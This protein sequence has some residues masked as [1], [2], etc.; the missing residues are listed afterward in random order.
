M[1]L[2]ERELLNSRIGELL[3]MFFV[4]IRL[5]TYPLVVASGEVDRTAELND[6]ANLA[7]NLP[8]YIVGHD[9]HALDSHDSLR[10]QVIYHVRKFY[11]NLADPTKHQYVAVLDLDAD[12]FLARHRDH[13]WDTPAPVVQLA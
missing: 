13:K 7:H 11:P 5:C 6:L 1:T 8:C 4:Q 9:E 12:T 10:D 3:H 2:T